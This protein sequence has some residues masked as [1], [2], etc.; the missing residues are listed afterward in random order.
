MSSDKKPV[1]SIITVCYN[2][3][4][5]IENTFKSVLNQSF[6][7]FEYIIV[8]GGSTDGTL[9]IINRYK[10]LFNELGIIFKIVSEKDDGIYDAMNKGIKMSSGQYI[11]LL[12][13]DDTYELNA[14]SIV[15][16]NIQNY[17]DYD[18]YHGLLRFKKGHQTLRIIGTSSLS[19]SYFMIEHPTCFISKDAYSKWGLYNLKYKLAADY[20]LISR[21]YKKGAKFFFIERII[22]NF[23]IE[24]RT[25]KGKLSQIETLM[26]MKD[27]GFIKPSTYLRRRLILLLKK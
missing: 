22:A 18:I 1:F 16:D 19:I 10:V 6:Q 3:Q 15:Q 25:Y 5:T 23:S 7:D 17:P 27:H 2:S 14:L 20:D 8:D 9:Q 26:I 13:S 11:A 12:N 24:G 4:D 21:M